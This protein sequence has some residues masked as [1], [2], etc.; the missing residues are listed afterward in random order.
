LAAD[1]DERRE[2]LARIQERL[3]SA[4]QSRED[5]GARRDKIEAELADIERNNGRLVKALNQLEADARAQNQR[6][7]ELEKRRGTLMTGMQSQQRALAGQARS[8]Y[9]TGRRE[10]LKLMLNQEDPSRLTRV[11]AYYSYLN[12]ARSAL[13]Q[14]MEQDLV[15]ARQVQGE[16]AIE[17]ERLRTTRQQMAAERAEL[18]ESRRTRRKLLAE[19]EHELRDQDAE[20]KQLRDNEQRLQDLL[21]SI[22]L[23]GTNGTPTE[24]APLIPTPP[25]IPEASSKCPIAGRLIGQ[26]GSPRMSGKWDGILIAA[27]EGAPVRAVSSGRVAFSDWLRGYGLL[28]IVDHGDGVMSLYAFNQSLYKSVGEPVAAGE[29]IAAVGASG[30]RAEAGLYFGIRNQ[31]A[32]V[33]PTPWC[34]HL[35]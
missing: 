11:L 3:K 27:E 24:S 15:A 21:A 18:D 29:V 8:A 31:G 26:F 16:L 25:S 13:L 4:Q 30:G 35:N 7:A 20:L 34:A 19:L 14:G 23:S 6:L 9:A 10:W 28:T 17:S 22:Q 2:E 12:H 33:D 5:M 32:V 1:P